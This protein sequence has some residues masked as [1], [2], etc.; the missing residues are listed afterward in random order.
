M[1]VL[2]FIIWDRGASSFYAAASRGRRPPPAHR[3]PVRL[4]TDRP[5]RRTSRCRH[6]RET[7]FE[8]TKVAKCDHADWIDSRMLCH[9][10]GSYLPETDADYCQEPFHCPECYYAS[11]QLASGL[12]NHFSRALAENSLPRREP[13]RTVWVLWSI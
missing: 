7:G 5:D 6:I 1:Y 9:R 4:R 13:L 8:R 3:K 2:E 11:G 10:I 12:L